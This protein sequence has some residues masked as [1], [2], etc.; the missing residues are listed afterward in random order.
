MPDDYNFFPET[1]TLPTESYQLKAY[2]EQN[3]NCVYIVKP[4]GGSQGKGIYLTRK[5]NSLL[6]KKK[7]V[8][9][10]YV[11]NPYVVDGYKFDFRL[12]VLVT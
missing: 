9:Q 1:W 10:K 5:I 11:E 8:I 7:I 12:Y 6:N 2:S 4:E 3:P